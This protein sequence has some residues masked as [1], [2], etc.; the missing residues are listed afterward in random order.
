MRSLAALAIALPALLLAAPAA[1]ATTGDVISVS[2]SDGVEEARS[3]DTVRYTVVVDNPGARPFSGMVNLRAPEFV[4]LAASDA[5]VDGSVA[6]WTVEVA[7]RATAEFEAVGVVGDA[8]DAAYQVVTLAEVVDARGGVVVRAADA[9]EIPGAQRPPDVPGL[10]GGSPRLPE[11][12]PLGILAA[13]AVGGASLVTFGVL[14][15]R[16]N[17]SRTG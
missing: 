14:F 1:A 17:R 11:W 4:E 6:T 7:A 12:L 16:R 2:V 5:T 8:P 10:T 13:A 15:A 9:D 3:G